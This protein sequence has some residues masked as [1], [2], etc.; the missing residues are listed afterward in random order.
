MALLVYAGNVMVKNASKLGRSF[1]VSPML[2]GLTI[3][4]LGTSMPEFLVCLLAA[5]RDSSDIAT[6]NIIGSNIANIGLILGI[7]ATIKP[8]TSNYSLLRVELPLMIVMSVVLYLLSFNLQ[9]G[10]LEGT[11]IFI[12]LPAFIIYT[13]FTT[14]SSFELD[15]AGNRVIPPASEKIKHFIL[16]LLGLSGLLLGAD[17]VVDK[18]VDLARALGVSE[19]VI[20]VTAV[21]VGT[22]L[23][24][25]S[26]SLIAV[27]KSEHELVVGNVIGSNMFNIGILGLVSVIQPV[28]INSNLIRIEYPLMLILS[29]MLLPMMKTGTTIRRREGLVLVGIYV[30]FISLLF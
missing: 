27:Y 15:E 6:G 21:A 23:P 2:I 24:E 20:G 26:A 7:T 14:T 9:L 17:L 4:S 11:F 5:V 13:Y 25:L 22:S 16:V 19:L 10:R 28:N 8:V 12:F 29:V 30:I 3:V 1:G 18:S